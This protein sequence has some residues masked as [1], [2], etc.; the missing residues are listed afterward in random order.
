[1]DRLLLMIATSRNQGC[2]MAYFQTKNSIF[3]YFGGPRN[4]KCWCILWELGIFDSHTLRHLVHFLVCN[5]AY[6]PVL[7]RFNKTNLPIL[8]ETEK[9]LQLRTHHQDFFS[10]YGEFTFEKEKIYLCLIGLDSI[11]LD[12]IGSFWMAEFISLL[13]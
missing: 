5:L 7:V 6:F 8:A 10:L 13:S 1:M 3:F 12:R 9:C 11:G 4:G 2:Q